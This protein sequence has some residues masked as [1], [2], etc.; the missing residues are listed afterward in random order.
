[1][2]WVLRAAGAAALCSLALAES[3]GT[4]E[5]T[6]YHRV[7]N[8]AHGSDKNSSWYPR[9]VVH[10]PNSASSASEVSYEGITSDL[11]F[12]TDSAHV[13]YQIKVVQGD[14]RTMDQQQLEKSAESDGGFVS[15]AKLVSDMV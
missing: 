10:L 3:G 8:S 5:Y 14:F 1:M 2:K 13:L 4:D 7:F 6:L 12:P 9:A 15:Y 11:E